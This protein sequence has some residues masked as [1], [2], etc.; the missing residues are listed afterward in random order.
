VVR[1]PR[2]VTAKETEAPK[3]T[4]PVV[5]APTP[6]P[7]ARKPRQARPVAPAALRHFTIS[8]QVEQVLTARDIR[9]ALR[10]VTSFGATTVIGITRE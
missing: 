10:Q 4:P 5:I 2:I 8:F 9:D 6:R 3:P 1:R 7:V